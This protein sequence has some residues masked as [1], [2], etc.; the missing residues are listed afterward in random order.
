MCTRTINQHMPVLC[1]SLFYC[2]SLM[3]SSFQGHCGWQ[4]GITFFL[5]KIF[6]TLGFIIP[7]IWSK[8]IFYVIA[9]KLVYLKILVLQDVFASLMEKEIGNSLFFFF[10]LLTNLK[11]TSNYKGWIENLIN[12]L[13]RAPI[14]IH[15]VKSDITEIWGMD[16]FLDLK[17][18]QTSLVQIYFYN[19][20]FSVTV[21]KLWLLLLL[22]HSFLPIQQH[23][24]DKT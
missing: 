16:Y 13:V 9:S 2:C 18:N 22:A 1:K 15:I 20:I 12:M 5:I 11:Y 24:A 8:I 6:I 23:I 10:C 21:E 7:K 3:F 19:E 17:S 4:R 14:L